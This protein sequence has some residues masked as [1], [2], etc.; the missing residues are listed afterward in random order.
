M[1]A[2]LPSLILVFGCLT[3]LQ[4][5]VVATVQMTGPEAA[6][7]SVRVAMK[8]FAEENEGKIAAT[9]GDLEP[10][11]HMGGIKK[12]LG[13][14]PEDAIAL[15]ANARPVPQIDGKRVIAILL[16][17][18]EGGKYWAAVEHAE[19]FVAPVV[20][21]KKELRNSG[22]DPASPVDAAES[23]ESQRPPSSVSESGTGDTLLQN[24]ETPSRGSAPG[25]P[26]RQVK[27][28]FV[29]NLPDCR[30]GR[31]SSLE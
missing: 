21:E 7:R 9:W 2:R 8:V 28:M 1:I 11:L 22:I 26:S 18:S 19:K 29:A 17:P 4:S 31:L 20:F 14:P 24:P 5:D 15:L 27:R 30:R 6:F 13:G 12:W 10:Y 16:I 23:S 25:F 3:I